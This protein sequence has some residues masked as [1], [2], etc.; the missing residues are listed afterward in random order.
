MRK[1]RLH[2]TYDEGRAEVA[3]LRLARKPGDKAVE[4][5]RVEP[6]MVLDFNKE[7]KLIGIEIV[8]PE[9]VTLEAINKILHKYG[10]PALS[11]KDLAPLLAA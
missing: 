4:S 7:G 2:V 9:H 1:P 8:D 3:Y 5:E 10:F 6:E 11:K